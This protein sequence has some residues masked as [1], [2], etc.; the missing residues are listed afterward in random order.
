MFPPGLSMLWES[1]DPLC[2]LKERFG[3]ASFNE[4][5]GWLT[6][7]MGEAWALDVQACERILISGDNAIAWIR[8]NRGTLVAKWSRDQDQFV[9]FAATA[10]LQH[11]LHGQGVPVAPPLASLNGQYRVIIDSLS[12]TV[13]PHIEG[14][15]LDTTEHS[16]VRRAG[17]CL[18]R[19]HSALAAQR[20]SR[21][22]AFGRLTGGSLDLHR[23][24]ETWLQH[25]DPG[26]VPAASAR[27]RDAVAALPPI[28][29]EPQL[30]HND[31]R[32]SNI[33][34]SGSEILAVLDFD[35]VAVDY[36]VSDLAN[37]FVVLGTRFTKW[38]PTPERVRAVFLQGYESVRP[39]TMLERR[40]LYVLVLLRGIQAIPPGDDPAG[41]ANA[42]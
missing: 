38:Q 40:W 28:D 37:T 13:Q 4:A 23:R 17:V 11:A 29:S 10:D 14:G 16:A 22:T 41:W 25:G 27:L 20:D 7:V 1:A 3:L 30:V 6:S 2:V 42:V 36:C 15:L 39:L 32:A 18:A 33:L 5:A 35:E 12:I 21:L 24:T 19:L 8:T 31:Y 9:K 34:T 26:M